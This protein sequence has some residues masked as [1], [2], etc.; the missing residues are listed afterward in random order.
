MKYAILKNGNWQII[1]NTSVLEINN[2][3]ICNPKHQRMLDEGYIEFDDTIPIGY[4]TNG[5]E[6]V[7]GKLKY[8]LV[9]LPTQPVYPEG[10]LHTNRKIRITTP[11]SL[12]D[13]IQYQSYFRKLSWLQVPFVSDIVNETVTYYFE[14]LKLS[15]GFSLVGTEIQHI[16]P[17]LVIES[18][19][20]FEVI[21]N[22]IVS[23]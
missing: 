7:N 20:E 16:D 13:E 6:V 2:K 8:K 10:W 21:D 9:E 11:M 1:S 23:I 19:G 12:G 17:R 5:Y 15:D 4:T 14:E 3:I 22:V 18:F